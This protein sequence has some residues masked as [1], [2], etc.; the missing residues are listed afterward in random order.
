M[1]LFTRLTFLGASV[2]A[3]LFLQSSRLAR[4]ETT[5]T[6][7]RSQLEWVRGR[8]RE[9]LALRR[10]RETVAEG[11]R[12]EQDVLFEAH[13]VM[14][15]AGIPR[16][17][18]ASLESSPD[19]PVGAPGGV[20]RLQHVRQSFQLLLTEV[21]LRDVGSFLGHWR[22]RD[23][24]WTP[25]RIELTRTSRGTGAVDHCQVRIIITAI[26]LADSASDR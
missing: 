1:S 7:A 13:T 24:L 18:L 17:R 16:A 12:A 23:P 10:A 22:T 9:V 25:T 26:H 14:A 19:E 2:L 20:G 21:S 11:E 5:A 3:V 6:T 15:E 4:A 8:A